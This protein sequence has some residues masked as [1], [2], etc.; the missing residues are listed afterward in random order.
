MKYDRLIA[1]HENLFRRIQLCFDAGKALKADPN[2]ATKLENFRIRY[3][4]FSRTTRE[5]RDIV[6]EI[7][8]AKQELKPDE[9]PSYEII[10]AFE[11][12]CD[13]IEYLAIELIK[14]PIP[15]NPISSSNSNA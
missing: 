12:L 10:D 11:D 1:K 9:P 7:V 5:Y 6:Q 3:Q 15:E 4:T 14:T 2:H 13:N 8:I